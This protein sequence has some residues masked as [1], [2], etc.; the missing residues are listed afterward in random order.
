M[1]VSSGNEKIHFD[2]Y[3]ATKKTKSGYFL[4]DMESESKG[5]SEETMAID[6]WVEPHDPNQQSTRSHKSPSLPDQIIDNMVDYL[7]RPSP[8]QTPAPCNESQITQLIKMI[9]EIKEA[10]AREYDDIRK[11]LHRIRDE[12][13][14]PE[15]FESGS[16]VSQPI[17]DS[18]VV[19]QDFVDQ[20]P[21]VDDIDN[22]MEAEN[23]DLFENLD[24]DIGPEYQS[25]HFEEPSIKGPEYN[26]VVFENTHGDIDELI[27][28]ISYTEQQNQKDCNNSSIN[29]SAHSTFMEGLTTKSNAQ[30]HLSEK[31]EISPYEI[32]IQEIE[33]LLGITY[34]ELSEE[35]RN[36][37]ESCDNWEL[38]LDNLE[39][40][41]EDETQT[42]LV[43]IETD[44]WTL[45]SRSDHTTWVMPSIHQHY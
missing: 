44:H 11:E 22:P 14:K 36:F 17:C 33:R 40:I 21:E 45:I 20:T 28:M 37:G 29:D 5:N 16:G 24:L 9:H 38:A 23:G 43:E 6:T 12:Q 41:K 4:D 1:E 13:Q 7:D 2:M 42:S 27:Q 30:L 10:S 34:D 39:E 8:I 18:V 32:D 25:F 26:F 35:A 3:A 15:M 19:M 31:K